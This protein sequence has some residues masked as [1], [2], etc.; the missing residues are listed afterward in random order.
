MID[1]FQEAAK[2]L[3]NAVCAV[4]VTGS[5]MSAES[6][7][8]TFR[9]TGGIWDKYPPE[10]YATIEAFNA[11]PDKIWKFWIELVNVLHDKKPNP[12]HYALA[13]LEKMGI[14]KAVVTQN[15]D[16]LHQDAG[17]QTVIEY[18]G[19]AKW[20]VCPRCRHRDLLDLAQHG[21]TA[22]FCF[23]GTPMRPDIVM[24]GEPIPSQPLVEAARFAETCDVMLVIGTSASTYPAASLP[25]FAKQNGAYIIEANTETTEFT[26]TI[27]DS[28]L[29][30]PSG[31]TLPR[32]VELV[33]GHG[34]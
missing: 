2:A 29:A 26:R 18:H 5:G 28:F 27:T 13:E 30:G 1:H 10:E 16:N 7:I 23:C 11:N 25:V 6:G 15:V 19:N 32:L 34:S 4:A 12:G 31:E 21:Q 9:G 20:L 14:L 22:P 3:K 17:S 33:K 24:Y 8:P